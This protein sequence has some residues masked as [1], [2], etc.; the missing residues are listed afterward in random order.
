MLRQRK[1]HPLAFGK[2]NNAEKA[3]AIVVSVPSTDTEKFKRLFALSAQ[4]DKKHGTTN[5]IIRLGAK[6]IVSI[7]CISTNLPTIDYDV[8]GCGGIPR[9]RVIEVF[10]PESAGKTTATLHFIAQ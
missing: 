10:G 3:P 5:S 6:N 9:G 8:F 7:P 4:L 1:R 2:K